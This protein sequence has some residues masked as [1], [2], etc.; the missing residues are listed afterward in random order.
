MAAMTATASIVA[1]STGQL[2]SVDILRNPD[3]V[4]AWNILQTERFWRF[5]S[6]YAVTIASFS[7]FIVISASA[8][9]AGGPALLSSPMVASPL[10]QFLFISRLSLL[11][12]IITPVVAGTV[13]V[14]LSFSAIT[15]VLDRLSG[16][17]DGAH[18]AAVPVLAGVPLAILMEMRLFSSAKWQQWAPVAAIA[19]GFVIAVSWGLYDFVKVVEAPWIGIPAFS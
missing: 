15:T 4:R 13:L 16:V 12:R 8:L 2:P 1:A 18:F 17:P 5:W 14:L 3:C 19:T 7:Q 11:R 6:G 10:I 9:A